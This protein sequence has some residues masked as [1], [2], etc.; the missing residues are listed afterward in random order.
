MAFLAEYDALP[1]YGPNGDQNGHACGHNWIAASTFAAC[2]ALKE[3]KEQ[4]ASP[5]NRLYGYAGGGDHQRE[6]H[7][8]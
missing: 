6:D 7:P 5:A 3:L 8:D 4:M 2:V 1:G